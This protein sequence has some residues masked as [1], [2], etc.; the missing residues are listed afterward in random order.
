ML[1]H[2]LGKSRGI[3]MSRFSGSFRKARVTTL[4]MT[5]GI[6]MT[7]RSLFIALFV[8]FAAFNLVACGPADFGPPA[9]TNWAPNGARVAGNYNYDVIPQPDG[10]HT[11]HVGPNNSDNVWIAAAPMFE[12]D[13]VAETSMYVPEGPTYDNEGNLYFSPLYP[14]EDVSLVSLDG[15]TGQRR[16]AITGDGINGGS[17]AV[18]ILNDPE[19]LGK[20]I[21]YHASYEQIMALKPDGTEIWSTASGLTLPPS[22]PGV[23]SGAHCY[24]FNYHPPTDSMIAVT[25]NG[26][27]LAFNRADGQSIASIGQLPGAPAFSQLPDLAQFIRDGSDALTDSV[28][29]QTPDGLSFFSLIREIIFGGGFM[30]T[31]YFGIDPNSGRIYVAGTADDATDGTIDGVSELGA[32]YALDLVD[33]GNGGLEFSI[34][35][36][37]TFIGGTGSTPTISEDGNR[38]YVSDNVG[39]IIALDSDLNELW[40]FDI[41]EPIVASVAVSPDNSEIY[42]VTQFDIFKLV[43][44][45]NSASL[46]WTATL[47]A[48]NGFENFNA[49]TPT[50]TANGIAV[51]VGGGWNLGGTNLIFH[52]GIGL[53]DRDTGQLRYFAEGR[54]ECIAVTSIA[55]DGG[56]YTANSPV[57]RVTGQVL[58]PGLTPDPIIGG[59]SR[60]KPIRLDLLVRDA[61]CAAQTRAANAA[62]LGAPDAASA[63]EDIRQIKVLIDQARAALGNAVTDGDIDNATASS[64]TAALDLAES[65][66]SLEGLSQAAAD[67]ATGCNLF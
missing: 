49:L 53:L 28:F 25:I 11:M 21:I 32:L 54:E 50:I 24:G 48:F 26:K 56:F 67:L 45:G 57:R 20:Q 46:E 39:N 8:F 33:D 14:E 51:S 35:N 61:V 22:A 64:V 2:A 44:Q 63:N 36:S 4:T 23:K 17:G 12:L 55:P 6:T 47:N 52:V 29:G 18:L 5:R 38:V 16:W 15:E 19:N 27:L 3:V 66:L 1:K 31:N 62:S 59:I 34:L 65:N 40:R 58:F 37:T 13:W 41:G 7:K 9:K 43:D 30:V 10:F 42:V 60:Y